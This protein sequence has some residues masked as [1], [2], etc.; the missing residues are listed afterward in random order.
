VSI[1]GPGIAANTVACRKQQSRFSPIT[2]ST[3]SLANMAD[4]TTVKTSLSPVI[5]AT[6]IRGRISAPLAPIAQ[7]LLR[8]WPDGRQ[9]YFALCR[10]EARGH[11]GDADRGPRICRQRHS[12]GR[13]LS[14][15][16]RHC[17][18]PLGGR[19]RRKK[20]LRRCQS[21]RP[22]AESA[23]PTRSRRRCFGCAVPE[24]AT[25]SGMPWS[26]TVGSGAMAS[27]NPVPGAVHGNRIVRAKTTAN[28][29]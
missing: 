5:T 27:S 22:S 17:D 11:R 14:G 24:R 6:H 3:S 8:R 18:R 19:G 15:Y 26:S 4:E 29:N 7:L 16:D 25:S 9:G 13:A 23:S 1:N 12:R 2:S 28:R 21:P 10:I 20:G